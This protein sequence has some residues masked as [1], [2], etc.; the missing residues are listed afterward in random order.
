MVEVRVSMSTNESIFLAWNML[1][2]LIQLVLVAGRGYC[3]T[4]RLCVIRDGDHHCRVAKG[5]LDAEH[6]YGLVT[7]QDVL[8]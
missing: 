8:S 2:I 1:W 4:L 6:L 5:A 7:P 3:A